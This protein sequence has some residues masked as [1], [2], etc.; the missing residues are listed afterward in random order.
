M[1]Q[2]FESKLTRNCW[3]HGTNSSVWLFAF[4]IRDFI[5]LKMH[6]LLFC[7]ETIFYNKTMFAVKWLSLTTLI[8][9]SVCD[10][11]Q[12]AYLY[13]SIYK[14]CKNS[15]R[16]HF[17]LESSW[18]DNIMVYTGVV[19]YLFFWNSNKPQSLSVCLSLQALLQLCVCL[20]VCKSAKI[21][22][23]HVFSSANNI[24]LL[25]HMQLFSEN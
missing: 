13:C 15:L 11:W 17:T 6:F 25:F 3:K 20:S 22:I 7:L 21:N 12:L 2:K 23:K 16:F 4:L 19:Q 9:V 8:T 10:E 1:Y 18:S 24:H 14:P 5:R